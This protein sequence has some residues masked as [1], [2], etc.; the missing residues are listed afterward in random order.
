M[1]LQ[2]IIRDT[3]FFEKNVVQFCTEGKL[4]VSMDNMGGGLE[5]IKDIRELLE[6][7][8][9]KHFKELRIPAVWLMFSLCLHMKYVRTASMECCLEL[10]S[11]F[12]ITL[13]LLIWSS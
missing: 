1:K 6:R 11:L 3:D 5:E 7:A 10:S 8:M 12:N 4:I 13:S 2:R 9:E